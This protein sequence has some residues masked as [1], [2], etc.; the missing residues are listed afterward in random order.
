VARPEPFRALLEK[1]LQADAPPVTRPAPALRVVSTPPSP[2]SSPALVLDDEH[3]RTTLEQRLDAVVLAAGATPPHGMRPLKLASPSLVPLRLDRPVARVVPALDERT[4]PAPRMLQFLLD[5]GRA[6]VVVD[7]S[8][9]AIPRL[10]PVQDS[11]KLPVAVGVHTNVYR[12]GSVVD[13]ET[14][15]RPLPV[16]GVGED[17]VETRK[18]RRVEKVLTLKTLDQLDVRLSAFSSSDT[19]SDIVEIVNDIRSDLERAPH[20]AAALALPA[21][22]EEG[23]DAITDF[24]DELGG[25]LD[26]LARQLGLE[27][28]VPRTTPPTR[29]DDS[30]DGEV[31]AD[32]DDVEI[33]AV[34]TP[35]NPMRAMV[36]SRPVVPVDALDALE[37][38]DGDDGDDG[39]AFVPTPPSGAQ[40]LPSS[41]LQGLDDAG[42]DDDDVATPA[43]G[44]MRPSLEAPSAVRFI[45]AEAPARP[46]KAALSSDEL[47]RNRARAHDLYLVALDDIACRDAQSAIVHLEL[48]LAYDD[49]TPLYHDL[50][51][52][53]QRKL[54]HKHPDTEH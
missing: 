52:Q 42:F 50:L 5:E 26:E 38:D 3:K 44:T 53:L 37:G 27:G 34:T 51:A 47:E 45:V 6:G 20:S 49:E 9:S 16:L 29:A 10:E 43:H 48:A 31:F 41:L 24:A 39:F 32:A 40:R 30:L 18:L 8:V 28:M 23:L 4:G 2:S 54:A 13:E 1:A 12:L 35:T 7:D 25:D 14:P 36:V 21:L 19:D 46:R 15:S 11:S 33:V 22:S 17:E